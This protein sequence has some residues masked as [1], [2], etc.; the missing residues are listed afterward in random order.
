MSRHSLTQMTAEK[1]RD[2]ERE[3][4]GERGKKRQEWVSAKREKV[5]PD[6]QRRLNTICQRDLE[7]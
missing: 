6:G 4:E 5:S 1:D 7:T 2:G 3:R